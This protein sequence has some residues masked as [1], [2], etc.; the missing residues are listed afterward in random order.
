MLSQQRLRL[1]LMRYHF[2]AGLFGKRA[3]AG[4]MVGMVVRCEDEFNRESV[5]LGEI[6]HFRNT[7]G[8]VDDS[9]LVRLFACENVGEIR[10][11]SGGY[12]FEK[13]GRSPFVAVQ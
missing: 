11:H 1:V 8:R 4:G 2:G 13:H 9:G 7:G 6:E 10:H 3:D 5:L 12:L